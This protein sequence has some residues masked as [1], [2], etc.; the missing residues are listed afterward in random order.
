VHA[1]FV[2]K[3]TALPCP[4]SR[5][6]SLVPAGEVRRVPPPHNPFFSLF[7]VLSASEQTRS[8]ER[9]QG[10]GVVTGFPGGAPPPSLPCGV[11]E[12]SLQAFP[13]AG[14]LL[15]DKSCVHP[16]TSS[17]FFRIDENKNYYSLL[18]PQCRSL[19][20]ICLESRRWQI[21]S[22]QNVEQTE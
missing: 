15:H 4:S 21:I 1:P 6:L 18:M 10:K 11:G 7:P 13:L 14:K 3:G 20:Y 2:R 16:H 8:V 5:R 19:W 9:K 17:A 12:G 22:G